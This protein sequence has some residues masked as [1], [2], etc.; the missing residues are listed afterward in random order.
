MK[1]VFLCQLW[2]GEELVDE[3]KV[4][5]ITPLKAK[6]ILWPRFNLKKGMKWKIIL[7][8]VLKKKEHEKLYNLH[9]DHMITDMNE[10]IVDKL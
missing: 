10:K 7:L 5:A 4:I 8:K 9:P 6:A 1:K 2:L 3:I